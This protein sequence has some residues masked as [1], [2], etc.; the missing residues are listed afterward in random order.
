[1]IH[2]R[3]RGGTRSYPHLLPAV[4]GLCG[5][6]LTAGP[7]IASAAFRQ[8]IAPRVSDSAHFAATFDS[9]WARIGRTYYDSTMRGLDWQAMRDALRPQAARAGTVAEL[10]TVIGRL[11]ES[12]GESHF[13]LIPSDAA[14]V[15]VAN[16][17]ESEDGDAGLELRLVDDELLVTRIDTMGPAWNAGIRPGWRLLSTDGKSVNALISQV[18]SAVGGSRPQFAAVHGARIVESRFT[19]P[20]GT[21]ITAEFRDGSGRA[22]PVRITRRVARG[23]PVTFGYLPTI[24]AIVEH[25]RV[26]RGASCVGVVRLSAWMPPVAAALDS[27]IVTYN[28]C[29]GIVL[30]LRGNPGGLA[31]MVM[32][33][34]GHFLHRPDSLGMLRLRTATLH[35][36]AN[37]RYVDA[38]GR[39]LE[40]FA[41]RLAILV[42][43]LS[44]STSEI[45]AAAMQSLGR[46]RVFGVRSPGYALPAQVNRLPNGDLL[47][48]VVADFTLP[49]GVRVEGRGVVPDVEIRLS[50]A[51][52]LEGRDAALDLAVD[53]TGA[54]VP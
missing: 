49:G 30:D 24:H 26:Q 46:S 48:H 54:D 5:M 42:D 16:G 4:A 31:G 25:R 2:D 36:V 52:L 17:G 19:G 23:E 3:R 29:A 21:E 28:S 27:A 10:R 14:Q 47:M 33:V 35:L 45:F 9:A 20:A 18:R 44:A 15:L 51:T 39:A 37:P 8:T 43:E 38:S 41:G 32:G 50:R 1:M 11:L 7:D 6:L 40:P 22:T 12:L 34:A 13:A 53:W